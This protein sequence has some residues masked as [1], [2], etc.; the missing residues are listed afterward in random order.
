MVKYLPFTELLC[1]M[2]GGEAL[3]LYVEVKEDNAIV[4]NFGVHTIVEKLDG[5]ATSLPYPPASP[6][7]QQLERRFVAIYVLVHV[8]DTGD[9]A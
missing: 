5:G 1:A 7:E 6:D 4:E 3:K 8:L 2:E 9:L